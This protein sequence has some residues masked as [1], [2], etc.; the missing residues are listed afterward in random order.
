VFATLAYW[1]RSLGRQDR[2]TAQ[3]AALGAWAARAAGQMAADGDMAAAREMAGT[4]GAP[5]Q[6]SSP[7]SAGLSLL[8]LAV[9]AGAPVPQ[10][11]AGGWG[12][13][14]PRPDHRQGGQVRAG[15]RH[16]PALHGVVV[17]Q[18]ALAAGADPP[19]VL[20]ASAPGVLAGA[21]HLVGL[22]GVCQ[23][24]AAGPGRP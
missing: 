23:F 21:G 6:A 11:G 4:D 17:L 24:A 18:R 10:A 20:H 5:G 1:A 3:G 13:C 14:R 12:P 16:P 9:A 7:A 2:L 22:N 15:Y 8:A 19:V